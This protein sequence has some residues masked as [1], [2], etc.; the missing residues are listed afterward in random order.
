MTVS[1]FEWT[2][3]LQQFRW[4]ES[5]VNDELRKTMSTAWRWVHERSVRDNVSLRLAAFATA[6]EAVATAEQ[7][8]GYI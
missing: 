2:Q 6:V 8:R 7:L 5:R 4:D 1:Y 3:N